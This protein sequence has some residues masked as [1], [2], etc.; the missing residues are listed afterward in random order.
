[1]K[2]MSQ[3]LKLLNKTPHEYF[4]MYFGAYWRWCESVSTNDAET[5]MVLANASVNKYYNREYAKCE[6]K[7]LDFIKDHQNAT[8]KDAME[9]YIECTFEM[10]NRKCEPIINQAKKNNIYNDITAN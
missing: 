1:M 6:A 8:P 7:F 3:I 10:F 5:Q 4:S 9:L 2:T